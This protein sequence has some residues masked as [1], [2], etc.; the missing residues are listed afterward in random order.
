MQDKKNVN[1][2]VKLTYFCT[3]YD[4]ELKMLSCWW[5]GCFASFKRS[6]KRASI[7]MP[8][9]TFCLCSKKKKL[10]QLDCLKTFFW[11]TLT[12][13]T[14]LKILVYL[15]NWLNFSINFWMVLQNCLK[16]HLG[17]AIY[18]LTKKVILLLLQLVLNVVSS[19]TKKSYEPYCGTQMSF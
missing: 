14:T 17:G 3:F 12:W 2:L 4:F 9:V 6:W 10:A 11:R 1:Y 16:L 13:T 7:F 15:R 8:I 5:G 19:A 18:C